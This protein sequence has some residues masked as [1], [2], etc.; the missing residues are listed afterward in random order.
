MQTPTFV[1]DAWMRAS[2]ES[3]LALADNPA[4]ARAKKYYHLGWMRIE[5]SPVGPAHAEDKHLIAQVVGIFAF[6]RGI[7]LKGYINLTL[8]KTG[9]QEAQPI[10]KT[11]PRAPREPTVPSI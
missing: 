5:M 2:W 1:Q 10:W 4:L 6:T 8:R 11:S 7:C 3:F 9:L